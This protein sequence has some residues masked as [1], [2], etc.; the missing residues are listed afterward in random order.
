MGKSTIN[1]ND[2]VIGKKNKG[3][4]GK[5]EGKRAKTSLRLINAETGITGEK[6]KKYCKNVNKTS[7]KFAE[8]GIKRLQ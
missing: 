1:K 2:R 4:R 3:Q 8:T 7:D 5:K 6:G